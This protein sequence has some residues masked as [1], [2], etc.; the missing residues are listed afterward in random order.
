M[1][2]TQGQLGIAKFPAPENDKWDVIRWEAA[3]LT[4]ARAAGLRVPQFRLH[5]I[6]GRP[7]LVVRRFD[8]DAGGRIG[9]VSAMTML[10]AKDGAEGSYVE[11]AEAIEE[12][13]PAASADLRELWRRIVFSRLISNTDDHLRNHG[14]LRTS[15]AGWSLSP[16]FD[17]NPNPQAGGRGFSTVIE[18]RRDGSGVEAAIELAGLFR[19]TPQQALAVIEE[20]DRATS[21]WREVAKAVGLEPGALERMAAAFENDEVRIARALRSSTT[22]R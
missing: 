20:I 22:L 10:E 15:T 4:L 16:A 21:S 9:Y 6:A 13:S 19:L 18:E 8:R 7:V 5:E 14:F 1:L 17:L 3:A 2:D 11:I 12:H